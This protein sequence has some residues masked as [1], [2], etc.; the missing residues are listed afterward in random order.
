MQYI[1]QPHSA[2]QPIVNPELAVI[3]GQIK[4]SNLDDLRRFR[5]AFPMNPNTL[6]RVAEQVR[7]SLQAK[8]SVSAKDKTDIVFKQLIPA[9]FLPAAAAGWNANL[10]FNIAGAGNYTVNV[11]NGAVSTAEGSVGAP[12]SVIS[13]DADTF[14]AIMRFQALDGAHMLNSPLLKDD[15]DTDTELDDEKLELVAGGKGSSSV[16]A[17]EAC[18]GD[19]CGAAACAGAA[20]GGD[21]CGAASCAGDVC[22]AATCAA[23]VG[24]GGVCAAAAGGAGACA[25]AACAAAACGADACAG[26]ACAAAACSAAACAAAACGADAGIGPDFGPCAVNV[27]PILPFI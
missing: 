26:D 27:V 22:G 21:A 24:G 8:K 10:H 3:A 20:C 7:P 18:G 13:T 25:G 12:T 1:D 5:R 19:A 17:G 16:C 23:D 9:T 14:N 2:R 4:A 15:E 11:R 6:L